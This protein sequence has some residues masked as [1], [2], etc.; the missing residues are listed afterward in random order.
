MN[1]IGKTTIHPFFFYTGK[2]AGYAIWII[3]FLSFTRYFVVQQSNEISRVVSYIISAV[4]LII[5][6]LSMIN[7][8]RSTRL[9]LPTEK[10]KFITGGF[11]RLSRNPMYLGFDLLTIASMIFAANWLILLLGI[12]SM[13]V[14]HFIILGEEAFL[15]KSFGEPYIKYKKT[16]RRYL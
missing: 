3:Y 9:G 12:Y 16:V 5:I 4:A 11:Y 8:G 1:L 6:I 15:E 2:F 14:Y 7:L 13:A 10:T